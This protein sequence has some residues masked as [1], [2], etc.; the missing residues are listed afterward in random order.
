MGGDFRAVVR[1]SP[2]TGALMPEHG[3]SR[4]VH[5]RAESIS[6]ATLYRSHD[7]VVAISQLDQMQLPGAPEGVAG[8][9]WLVS[10]S[11]HGARPSMG[12]MMR[13]IEAFAMPAWDE[14]NHYPGISRGLFC[15][16]EERWRNSCECK[17]T[18]V[19][20]TDGDYQWTTDPT[21]GCRGC[22]YRKMVLALVGKDSPCPIHDSL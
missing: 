4:L 6:N 5:R 18:E 22:D 7:G 16:V 20:I 19:L 14:D 17:I 13:V 15:P 3:F 8:P 2:T 21:K 9:T 10:V 1:I 11:D 12:T